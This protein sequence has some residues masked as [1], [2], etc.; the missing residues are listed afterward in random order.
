[1][2]I[3]KKVKFTEEE[4]D[5]VREVYAMANRL[6]NELK[7]GVDDAVRLFLA[8]ARDGKNEVDVS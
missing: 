4:M 1:M 3:I 5:A 6:D 7:Y 8:M 2:N